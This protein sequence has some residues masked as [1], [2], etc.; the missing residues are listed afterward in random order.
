MKTKPLSNDAHEELLKELKIMF[1]NFEELKFQTVGPTI[2]DSMKQKALIALLVASVAIIL[3]LAFSFRH[4]PKELSS[5]RFGICA[6][7]AL[8]HDLVITFGLFVFLGKFMGVEI[9][10]LFITAML[11]ILGF[12]V[13]DT[14]VVFDRLREHLNR[15]ERGSLTDITNRALTETMARSI[16]TSL[17]VVITLTAL[18]IFG[19]ASIFYFILALVVGIVVGTYSSVGVATALL[20]WSYNRSHKS[21]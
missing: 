10:A 11:T 9:D 14:I 8:L 19:S 21:V 6:V 16:N 3:Y 1:G 15:G 13:H 18:L 20:V 12:S 2:G 4:V 17:S 7:V 5:W